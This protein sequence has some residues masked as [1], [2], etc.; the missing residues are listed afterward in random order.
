MSSP[1]AARGKRL[2]AE[3]PASRSQQDVPVIQG[4]PLVLCYLSNAGFL[5]KLRGM[6]QITELLDTTNSAYNKRG[7]IR[8]VALDK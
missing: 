7:C 5:Q 2:A 6:W 4:E 8:Q 1:E 3:T